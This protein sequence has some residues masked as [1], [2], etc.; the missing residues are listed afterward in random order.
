MIP[1]YSRSEKVLDDIVS[2]CTEIRKR[3]GYR[4]DVAEIHRVPLDEEKVGEIVKRDFP[5][6]S[7]WLGEETVGFTTVGSIAQTPITES[8]IEVNLTSYV[9]LSPHAGIADHAQSEEW[10]EPSLHDLRKVLSKV[11]LR[12]SKD[13]GRW[14][15]LQTERPQITREYKPEDEWASVTLK[16]MVWTIAQ[17]DTWQ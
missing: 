9:R 3:N 5:V 16:F 8:V 15:V 4:V 1:E 2:V 10:G 12:H 6:L 11:C 7:V 14:Q 17:D 13:E